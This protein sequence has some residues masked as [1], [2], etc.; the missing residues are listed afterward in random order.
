[1]IESRDLFDQKY[2]LIR[3]IDEGGFGRVYEALH[4]AL[5]RKVALKV[6][7]T[8]RE[9][10]EEC[11][12]RFE[13]EAL[14]LS[15]LRHKNISAFYGYGVDSE[16]GAA[17]MDMEL[18]DGVH[19]GAYVAENTTLSPESTLVIAEQLA[20]ALGCAHANGIV[21][22][23]LKPSN[24]MLVGDDRRSVKL[25]DFGLA[26]AFDQKSDHQ[27]LTAEGVAVGTIEFM[28]PEQCRG[29]AAD[30]RSDIYALGCIIHF[31]L[32]GGPPFRADS[33]ILLMH[34]HLYDS[35]PEIKALEA[36]IATGESIVTSYRRCLEKEPEA[37]YQSA[38]DFL[39]AIRRP[40]GTSN[41]AS[42]RR[43]RAVSKVPVLGG[44]C[45]TAIICLVAVAAGIILASSAMDTVSKQNGNLDHRKA[46]HETFSRLLSRSRT[47][48][49]Y[50]QMQ[51]LIAEIK[52]VQDEKRTFGLIDDEYVE[53]ALLL[54]ELQAKQNRFGT[55]E[56]IASSAIS[57]CKRHTPSV[58]AS[59]LEAFIS[60]NHARVRGGATIIDSLVPKSVGKDIDDTYAK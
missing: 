7:R 39:D 17:Y 6:L 22:R 27:K 16:S 52:A 34:K 50:Y 51:K 21:H 54:S 35:P 33:P 49:D 8:N 47:K 58:D 48:L 43:P 20:E 30:E 41:A 25:V 12:K 46:S 18:I 53:S 36:D 5:D 56:E 42:I 55:A 24:I 38:Q 15:Q 26:R 40:A 10:L 1:M 37:R 45:V 44:R 32:T 57:V 19:L 11:S 4:V 23:D 2:E 14:A 13:R 59:R 29:C 60:A 28:S 3:L 9:M 31:C